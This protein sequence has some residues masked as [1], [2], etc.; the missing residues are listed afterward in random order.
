MKDLLPPFMVLLIDE[1]DCLIQIGVSGFC[2]LRKEENIHITYV[3]DVNVIVFQGLSS[4]SKDFAHEK[5]AIVQA[6]GYELFNMFWDA[7]VPLHGDEYVF[8][9][10][11]AD[12]EDSWFCIN[13]DG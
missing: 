1:F 3:D 10:F 9:V 5:T 13:E 7:T 8:L 2:P 12:F 11:H 4:L 6:I